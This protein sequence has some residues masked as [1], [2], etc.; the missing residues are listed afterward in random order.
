MSLLSTIRP[1]YITLTREQVSATTAMLWVI[2]MMERSF[3][4]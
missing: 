2:M 3:S 4:R 1:A